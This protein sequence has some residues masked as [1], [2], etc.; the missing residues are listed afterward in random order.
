M[1]TVNDCF[2]IRR[3]Y[4]TDNKNDMAEHNDFGNAR[5]FVS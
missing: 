1:F 3:F 2:D 4:E 5:M